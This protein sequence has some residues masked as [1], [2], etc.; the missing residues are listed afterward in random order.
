MRPLDTGLIAPAADTEHLTPEAAA[1]FAE[2]VPAALAAADPL[3][4]IQDIPL[5]QL[6][7]DLPEIEAPEF[8][9]SQRVS[10]DPAGQGTVPAGM[11]MLP[12]AGGGDPGDVLA[13][14]PP[15]V[16]SGAD[17]L[18]AGAGPVLDGA[19]QAVQEAGIALGAAAAPVTQAAEQAA[20][21]LS[22][23]TGGGAPAAAAAA[24][25]PAMPA[26]P[27]T[28]LLD[29]LS[30]P[31]LPGIDLLMQPFLDLLSSFGTGII[32]A[33]DPTAILSKSSQVIETAMTV[34]KGSLDTV[35]QLWQGQAARNAQ[36]AGQ[37][38]QVQ[39]QETSQRGIDISAL[40]QDAAG[41]VERG[42]A[43]LLGI[44]STFATQAAALA[45]VIV[46]PPAQATLIA[47][48]TEHLGHAVASVN[49][50]RGVLA[51]KTA[52][53]SAA[54][55]QLIAPGGGPPPQEVA[56]AVMQNIAE[57]VMSQAKQS[58]ES[59]TT[60]AG[61]DAPSTSTVPA[62][63][64][65]SSVTPG[66]T[67]N[68]PGS[69][70][71]VPGSP[72]R[73]GSPGTTSGTPGTPSTP[74]VTG[75]PNTAVVSPLRSMTGMPGTTGWPGTTATPGTSTSAAGTSGF[76]GSPG[77]AGAGNRGD[78]EHGRSVQPYQSRTGNDDLT[79]PLGES[80]PEVIGATH[81]DEL[82]GTD[83]EQDQF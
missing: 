71:Y 52:E 53:L 3:R 72:S 63:T 46:T 14:L 47:S 60:A 17:A 37:Q 2:Q 80:T 16:A 8:V 48:A 21:Q 6:P 26:D 30:L 83:Y 29:G 5:P 19:Q 79:G 61:V 7:A 39:S 1:A 55:S 27:A 10:D 40:T 23:L 12:G 73:T 24:A 32:G 20:A 81:T 67:P 35:D 28:A 59:A 51:G 4:A 56:Q 64:T 43:E 42:N 70:G 15:E 75:L 68:S 49:A 33:L 18:L 82:F 22:A 41:V 69:P 65:P 34:A 11:P 13:G 50:T 9:L 74:K 62:S 54:V 25:A 38:A 76:M 77:A 45:P 78:D 57:P 58:V 66:S 36:V 31:A 44:A